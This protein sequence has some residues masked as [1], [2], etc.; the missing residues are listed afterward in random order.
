K[1]TVDAS[2]EFGGFN[3]FGA[4]VGQSFAGDDDGAGLPGGLEDAD[5][6]GVV[7]QGGAFVIPDKLE[8]FARYEWIDFDGVFYRN[9]SGGTA[10]GTGDLA[11]DDLSIITL[12]GNYY[13]QKH[14]AKFTLDL[15]YALDPVP[16]TNTATGLIASDD[17]DQIAIRGQFQFTF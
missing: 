1:Y 3:L 11:E 13:F 10:G 14:A 8:L 5:Q 4:I 16:A 6:F 9:S 7:V 17:D 12:G 2:A 15:Q